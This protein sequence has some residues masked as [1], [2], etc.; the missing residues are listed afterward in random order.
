MS[1]VKSFPIRRLGPE[2]TPEQKAQ[3]EAET[4]KRVHE[5]NEAIRL[6][7]PREIE[8]L[9]TEADKHLAEVTRLE[10]ALKVY[11]DLRKHT[12]RWDKITYY[13]K[14]VNALVTDYDCRHNCGCCADSPLEVFPYVDT[15]VGKVY[16]DPACFTVGERDPLYGGDVPRKGWDKEMRDAGIPEEIIKRVRY[17][18]R[19]EAEKAKSAAE[20]IYGG[21]EEEEANL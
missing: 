21:S 14:E 13:T 17:H 7:V 16:S 11:P 2:E 6:S 15:P 19:E 3:R 8:K 18:F 12:W 20:E 10:A 9:R 5:A 1:E 4:A